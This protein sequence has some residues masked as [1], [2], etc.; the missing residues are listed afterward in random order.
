MV[1]DMYDAQAYLDLDALVPL[2][3][4]MIHPHPESRLTAEAALRMFDDIYDIPRSHL[5]WRL[6]LRNESAPERIVYDT[7]SAAKVGLSLVVGGSWGEHSS[8]LQ[9]HMSLSL[10]T[11]D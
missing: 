11:K 3:S 1:S 9:S 7:I 8:S 5:L 10:M 6:R 4:A 2:I